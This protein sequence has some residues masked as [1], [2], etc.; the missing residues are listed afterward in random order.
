MFRGAE[1][2][3]VAWAVGILPGFGI[4][5]NIARLS[6]NGHIWAAAGTTTAI[7]VVLGYIRW[8]YRRAWC[9][10]DSSG[11]GYSRGGLSVRHIDWADVDAVEIRLQGTRMGTTETIRVTRRNGRHRTL[12]VVMSSPWV[13]DPAF[14]ENA[15]KII[16]VARRFA[17]APAD[18]IPTSWAPKPSMRRTGIWQYLV[19]ALA[20]AILL[21]PANQIATD[22]QAAQAEL[23]A[24]RCPIEQLDGTVVYS[25]EG[26][27]LNRY[28]V[29]V[30]TVVR[31]HDG[32]GD[33]ELLIGDNGVSF[34]A[35]PP[36]LSSLAPGTEVGIEEIG[37]GPVVAVLD[38][39]ASARTSSSATHLV[40][41][42]VASI[43]GMGALALFFAVWATALLRARIRRLKVPFRWWVLGCLPGLLALEAI[44]FHAEAVPCPLQPSWYGFA[45]ALL[46]TGLTLGTV[47]RRGLTLRRHSDPSGPA[48]PPPSLHSFE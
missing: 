15:E 39:Q 35:A 9:R 2:P 44:S 31:E 33:V 13:S 19:A 6:L 41:T 3:K 36:W 38:G 32:F 47:L 4:A 42:D 28:N 10:V 17:A 45:A 37:R 7:V 48:L 26:A 8:A 18:S 27:C 12:P 1:R 21:V 22:R 34:G 14:P 46:L 11:I 5:I 20:L 29:E 40:D 43:I 16:A 24:S 25:V 23:S 30:D